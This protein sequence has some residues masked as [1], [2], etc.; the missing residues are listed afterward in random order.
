MATVVT[1]PNLHTP[2]RIHVYAA[3]AVS[4][5]GEPH[6]ANSHPPPAVE[7]LSRGSSLAGTTGVPVS[8]ANLA[9]SI[10]GYSHLSGFLL[11]E[12]AV[13]VSDASTR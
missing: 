6:H 11:V 3:R 9:R 8:L 10:R 12:H 4:A 13:P 2:Y 1:V 7:I 5:I